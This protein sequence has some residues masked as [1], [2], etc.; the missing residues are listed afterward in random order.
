[1]NGVGSEK[2]ACGPPREKFNCVHADCGATFTTQ[3]KLKEHESVHTGARPCQCIV[4]GC[5]RRFS[6]RSH[7]SRHML[8]HKGLKQFKCK[9]ANC[10]KSFFYAS[11]LKRHVCYAHGDKNKYFKCNQPDCTLTFKKRRQFKLHLQQHDVSAK[12]KCLKD[13]CTEVF[14]SHIAR[15]AHEKK[16]AGY[17]CPRSNCDVH[18]HT[19]GKL[20]KHM[21]KHSTTFECQVCKKVYK[22]ADALRRHKRTHASHKPVLVCPKDNCQAYFSTTFNL[23]HHIRKVHLELLKYKC[24]F[25]D[26]PR[27]FAM[28][29][30]MSR[31]LLHHDTNTI[32]LKKRQRPKKPWQKR[33]NGHQLPIVEE[34]L[35]RLFALRMRISRRAKVETN[36]AGLFNERKIPHYVDPE[37]NLRNLFSIKQP[38]PLKKP[39][40]VPLKS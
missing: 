40:A 27:M 2:P 10:S 11:K 39:V 16:H 30:S 25:P 18:E 23:Q 36:L 13:G 5:G 3:R 28:R 26:C 6:R 35:R 38:R 29:E 22:K 15:K 21:A 24:S 34:D 7:L 37:V 1:M 31:H 9:F 8:E 4:A 12:F 17:P 20:Q 32:T 19:W 33:L 14:D